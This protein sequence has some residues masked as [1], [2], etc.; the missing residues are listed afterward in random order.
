MNQAD[1]FLTKFKGA[2]SGVLRW[3]QLDALWE[4]IRNDAHGGWYVYAVGHEPPESAV[5]GDKLNE[6]ITE[7][8][9]LL[10]KDHEED[11]CGIVYADDFKKPT[12]VKIY[13]PNNLGVVCGS[14]DNPP[15]P[16]WVMSKLKPVSLPDAF[17][18]PGNRRRWWQRVFGKN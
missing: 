14:S 12:F 17:P 3:P 8:D 10:R 13:D 7:I 16:G 5:A 1:P 11:Y 4:T 15:L 2:F 18:P 9:R 6:F